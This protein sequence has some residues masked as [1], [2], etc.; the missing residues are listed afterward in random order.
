M[1]HSESIL[2]KNFEK[3]AWINYR[4]KNPKIIRKMCK[5]FREESVNEKKSGKH[6]WNEILKNT[7]KELF[8]E[9][10]PGKTSVQD[11]RKKFLDKNQAEV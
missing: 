9:R 7:L 4:K 5:K 10:I 2:W 11:C 3:K 8:S 1:H 6:P